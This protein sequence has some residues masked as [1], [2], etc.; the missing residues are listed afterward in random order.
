MDWLDLF[1]L[2]FLG[3]SLIRGGE[4]GFVRQFFSTVGFFAG[5]FLGA[6]INSLVAGVFSDPG[7]KALLAFVTVIGF[8]L[9]L[10]STG[11]YVGLRIKFHL[12][13][14][15]LR[16]RLD[17][18]LG[19]ALAGATL[20]AA[21][22]LGATV[23]RT[24]PDSGWQRQIRNSRIVTLLD[25]HLPSAPDVVTRLGHLI[26]PNDF[27]QVFTGLEPS[28]KTDAPLPD[29]GELTPA[30]QKVRPS[31]VKVEG[32]GCDSEVEGSGFVAGD[33]EV[34]TNAH[35]VAGVRAPFVLDQKGKHGAKVVLFDP[36]LDIAILRVRSLAGTPLQLAG[37]NATNGT[38]A[39]VL[40]YPGG[41][42]FTASPGVVLETF[43]ARGRNIYNQGNT[44]REI[45]SVKTNLEHGNSGGPLIDKNGT[46]I[47]VAFAQSVSYDEIGYAL[48]MSK[49]I[50][51]V[52]QARS[53]QD[54][55][56]TRG[57]AN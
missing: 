37:Q 32:E 5:L 9:I 39:A 40:G 36:D 24:I 38:P 28:L 23:L 41:G 13:E 3:A 26:A 17:K 16:D 11:E 14:T 46:V 54:S 21:V 43:L 51:A 29:M 2:L 50:D 47:G 6:W 55:V 48:T 45:Y 53:L 12:K 52:M 25:N 35:V 30:V 34:V 57:C 42:G 1:I 56:S 49:V 33:G 31:V 10:M 22:W 27:P 15:D 8:A 44:M 4:V 20:L 18:V 7:A 19:S